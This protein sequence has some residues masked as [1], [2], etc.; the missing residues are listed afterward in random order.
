MRTFIGTIL[1]A[2]AAGASAAEPK[3][4]ENGGYSLG[5]RLVYY[6]PSDGERGTWNPGVQ[7]RYF[8]GERFALEGAADY[9]RHLF[10]ETTVHT[11]AGQVSLM[12]YWN[13]GRLRPLAL[14]GVGYYA[15]RV[16]GPAYRRNIGRFG[17]HLGLGAEVLLNDK[18]SID[19][20]YRHVW[21]PDIET[22]DPAAN[23]RLFKRSGEQ[24]SFALNR[25]F[26]GG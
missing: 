2:L 16:H 18:W 15:S 23:R 13:Y 6:L 10:P 25:L 19:A 1:L 5:P 26:G 24:I 21:L 12:A 8:L 4:P 22:R 17:P 14:A 9:Q 3:A 7:A 11:A 20:V